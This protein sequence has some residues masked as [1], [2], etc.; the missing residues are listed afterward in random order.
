MAKLTV[1]DIDFKGKRVL[2]R[3][4]FNVPL[5]KGT[6][7]VSDNLR[8]KSALPTIRYLLDGG[9]KL[10]LMSHLGRPKGEVK[11][12][13]SLA[14]VR[15]ELENLLSRSISF[16][17][18]CTS[19][20]TKAMAANLKEGEILLLENLRFHKGETKNEPQFAAELASLGD[21]FVNDAFGTAHRAHASTEGVPQILKNGVAGFLLEKELR[22]LIEELT[23]AKRPIVAVLGGAKVSGKIDV[24]HNLLDKVDSVI[25]GG[26]MVFTFYKALGYE[27]GNS[28]LEEDRIEMAAEIID[29]FKTRGVELQLP[30]D[31]LVADEFKNGSHTEVVSAGNMPMGKIGVDIGPQTIDQFTEIISKART[32]IWNGPMGVFE[33]DDFAKGTRE[34]A[35][36]IG[37]LDKSKSLTIVG[38]GDS[39]AAVAAF[40]LADC[41]THISTGGGASLELLEGKV[42]PGVAILDDELTKQ[43]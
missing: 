32:V 19:S 3:V 12:E 2:C 39:A 36:A 37:K 10:I 7:R 27:I 42:L 21:I 15:A 30:V 34:I 40:D 8:I 24:I 23:A 33:I 16:A 11:A 1:R 9:A 20:E 14:P 29:L 4:D 35:M 13:Y 31:I 22:F 43:D 25:I 17:P 41:F 26:G 5:E 18:D 38:G 6:Q 28:L